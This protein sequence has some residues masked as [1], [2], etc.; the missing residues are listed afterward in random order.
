M[1]TTALG[2][3]GHYRVIL[4]ARSMLTRRL[5]Q[6]YKFYALYNPSWSL[7][8]VLERVVALHVNDLTVDMQ[9]IAMTDYNDKK[10]EFCW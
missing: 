9:G 3:E 4:V 7:L 10:G 8:H 6:V 5:L 2:A 1:P